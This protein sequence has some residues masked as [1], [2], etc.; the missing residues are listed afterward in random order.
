M[1]GAQRSE[2]PSSGA[3]QAEQQDFHNVRC[4]MES[5]KRESVANIK[6][7][8]SSFHNFRFFIAMMGGCAFGLA[9]VF[10][11]SMNVAIL[12]M[13]NQ[14]AIYMQMHPNSTVQEFL[15]EGYKLGGDFD[16]DN[17]IQHYIMSWY[18]IT[19]TLPQVF[20]TK[21]GLA[22]G[23]RSA[24][25]LSVA[26]GSITCFL[27]PTAAYAGWRWVVLLRLLSGLVAS[28]TIPLV[29]N[30]VEHWLPPN[31]IFL[32]LTFVHI[33]QTSILASSSV[34][35]GYL[36][37]IHWSY[38]FY[39]TGIAGLI[40][41]VIWYVLLAGRPE[42]SWILSEKE[43]NLIKGYSD[44]RSKQTRE[45]DRRLEEAKER[46]NKETTLRDFLVEPSFYAFLIIWICHSGSYSTFNFILPTYLRQFLKVKVADVGEYCSFINL[47]SVIAILW[48]NP[49]IKLLKSKL[50]LSDVVASR[51]VVIVACLSGAL[52][53]FYVGLLHKSQLPVLFVNRC[54]HL[55]ADITVTAAFMRTYSKTGLF[56]VV[57]SLINTAGQLSVALSSSTTGYILDLTGQSEA[58]WAGIFVALGLSHIVLMLV[59]YIFVENEPI[60]LR[61]QRRKRLS[62]DAF[63]G[64]STDG[65][66]T[67]RQ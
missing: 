67:S 44:N 49:I 32:G 36:V 28:P 63:R 4:Q 2:E 38:N 56:T 51:V 55:G 8:N 6:R 60:E 17:T 14:T 30:L 64:I 20:A 9:I 27:M 12:S 29:F 37:S 40:F 61:T 24:I 13:V 34:I 18:M 43:L 46:A 48:P 57:F 7:F 50:G 5:S 35:A 54:F 33:L 15:N 11:Y 66:N 21:L 23:V 16:W 39:A 25:P 19:Y 26:L 59:F 1:E 10:R 31:E 42:D 47:G 62:M 3:V 58:G 45:D 52:T 22:I 53:W 41:S 65:K